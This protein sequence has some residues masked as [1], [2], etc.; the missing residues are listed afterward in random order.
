MGERIAE[1]LG[2]A[3][4]AALLVIGGEGVLR[5]IR[6]IVRGEGFPSDAAW[7]RAA[8]ARLRGRARRPCWLALDGWSPAMPLQ[9]VVSSEL[10]R[11][12]P[13]LR[14]PRSPERLA[15]PE[16]V[17]AVARHAEGVVVLVEGLDAF[18]AAR[19]A[20]GEADLRF[21]DEL[22]GAIGVY[23]APLWIVVSAPRE[24]PLRRFERVSIPP[25]PGDRGVDR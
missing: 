8:R 1:S 20:A 19:G 9:A 6:E 22:A 14:L 7:L 16:L 12:M 10:A 25:S 11:Q 24:L 13:S 5:S 21:L 15:G 23:L 4:G 17:E 18:L 3:E 2:R